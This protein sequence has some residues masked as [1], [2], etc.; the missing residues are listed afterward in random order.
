MSS[1]VLLSGP[2]ASGKTTLAEELIRRHDFER[3]KSSDHLRSICEQPAYEV[4]RAALQDMGDRLDQETDYGWLVEDVAKPQIA[5]RPQRVRW[6]I[7][8][9][10]K[11]RQIFHFRSSFGDD[12]CHVHV[13]APE[14][15]LRERFEWRIASGEHHEGPTSYEQGIAHPNEISARA[16]ENVAD[17]RIDL[18]Q[19]DPA[20]AAER[21]V[22]HL[23][24]RL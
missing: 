20:E 13:S 16:L 24:K 3:V 9:V 23:A 22:E 17:L 12:V 5:A 15:V 19:V 21:I 18:S 10:R 7:D 11:E 2:I 1:I 6:L 4:S 14:E 8:S